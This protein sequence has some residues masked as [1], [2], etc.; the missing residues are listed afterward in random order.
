MLKNRPPGALPENK[1]RA[2]RKKLA[3]MIEVN[4]PQNLCILMVSNQKTQT[5]P[6]SILSAGNPKTRALTEI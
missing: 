6:F 4:N 5:Q 1:K 2:C 3:H